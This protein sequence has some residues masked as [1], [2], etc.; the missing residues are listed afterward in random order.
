[1]KEQVRFRT[2]F[3]LMSIFFIG[4]IAMLVMISMGILN[5]VLLTAFALVFL[6]VLGYKCIFHFY[7]NEAACALHASVVLGLLTIGLT[8]TKLSLVMVICLLI[9]MFSLIIFDFNINHDEFL[10]L[11]VTLILVVLAKLV[12]AQFLIFIPMLYSFK[13]IYS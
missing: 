7:Q 8:F 3:S 4:M 9:V 2:H 5:H 11:L 13:I 6:F 10:A 1:M 12:N